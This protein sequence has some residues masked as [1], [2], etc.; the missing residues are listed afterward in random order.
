LLFSKLTFTVP[1]TLLILIL[2]AFGDGVNK[3]VAQKT[4]IYSRNLICRSQG[5]KSLRAPTFEMKNAC[6]FT[7]IHQHCRRQTTFHFPLISLNPRA[8]QVQFRRHG[9][10][11]G[12]NFQFATGAA[13]F[14]TRL[15]S[16]WSKRSSVNTWK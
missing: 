5:K 8:H 13:G 1:F 7:T 6:P 10:R 16:T 2:C 11:K 9:T 12:T 15:Y 14:S 4:I 3:P